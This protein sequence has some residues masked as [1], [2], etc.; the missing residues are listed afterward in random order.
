MLSYQRD[1]EKGG[2]NMKKREKEYTIPVT[3]EMYGKITVEAESLQE[4]LDMVNNDTD[5][6]GEPF[7]FPDEQDYAEGSFKVSDGLTIAFIEKMIG[8]YKKLE[9]RFL[10]SE[11]E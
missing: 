6:Y 8:E 11:V 7:S 9:D 5:A 3:W 10:E 1:G 2:V 4:A